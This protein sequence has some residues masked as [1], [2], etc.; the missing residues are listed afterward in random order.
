VSW[1]FDKTASTGTLTGIQG[2]V[3]FTFL[4]DT[5]VAITSG[6]CTFNGTQGGKSS[7]SR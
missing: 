6:A 2:G 5:P 3:S 7:L 1:K 4:T